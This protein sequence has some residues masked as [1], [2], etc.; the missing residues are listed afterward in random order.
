MGE[1]RAPMKDQLH[2]VLQHITIQRQS[3]KRQLI[4]LESAIE[5]LDT[6]V[7]WKVVGNIMV[8]KDPA[9]LKAQLQTKIDTITERIAALDAQ[10]MRMKEKLNADATS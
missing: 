7:A 2:S 4:E 10:E 9:V 6:D 8:K 5:E 1:N 3:A